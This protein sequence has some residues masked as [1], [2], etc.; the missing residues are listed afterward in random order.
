MKLKDIWNRQLNDPET[1]SNETKEDPE[2]AMLR[3]FYKLKVKELQDYIH[4]IE[5][6]YGSVECAPSGFIYKVLN[7]KEFLLEFEVQN[8]LC[9]AC[10]P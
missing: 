2:K 7:Q 6:V 4:K 8:G 3:E 10:S 9:S 5:D 1:H